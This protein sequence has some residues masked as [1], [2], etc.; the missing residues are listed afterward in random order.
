[1]T[2]IPE[3]LLKRAQAA[4]AKA[5]GVVD[6][7][8]S[9]LP[10]LFKVPT[11]TERKADPHDV[12]NWERFGEKPAD[13]SAR[14]SEYLESMIGQTGYIATVERFGDTLSERETCYLSQ[15]VTREIGEGL[16]LRLGQR[17][18]AEYPKP[19]GRRILHAARRLGAEILTGDRDRSGIFGGGYSTPTHSEATVA[20][21]SEVW[22]SPD[23]ARS[24]HVWAELVVDSNGLKERGEEM[25]TGFAVNLA[26]SGVANDPQS[27]FWGSSSQ[28]TVPLNG[29]GGISHKC[30]Y[31]FQRIERV[32]SDGT[33]P[34][35][36]L[37]LGPLIAKGYAGMVKV[38]SA[39]KAPTST[40]VID[41]ALGG[42]DVMLT[43]ASDPNVG[44]KADSYNDSLRTYLAKVSQAKKSF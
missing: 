39:Y 19:M 10:D 33:V 27:R 37:D 16:F 28:V 18:C 9:E 13:I 42:L 35:S 12:L 22:G 29:A 15:M 41:S 3:H 40:E 6:S 31:T 30:I 44:D 26:G 36:T 20:E 2:E 8:G 1:M 38:S 4:K 34:N 23:S 17:Q 24:T 32:A 43:M 21:F 14:M 25:V 5:E 11:K 7:G